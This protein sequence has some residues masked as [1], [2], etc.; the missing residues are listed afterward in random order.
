MSLLHQSGN[1][2][3]TDNTPKDGKYLV[4][5]EFKFDEKKLEK[6]IDDS[7]NRV[8]KRINGK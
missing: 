4:N 2:R 8:L 6:V 7:L 1:L 3:P 5:V